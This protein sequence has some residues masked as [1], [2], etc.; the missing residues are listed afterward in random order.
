MGDAAKARPWHELS[1]LRPQASGRCNQLQIHK[2]QRKLI[3]S[4][5]G[6]A[7][8]AECDRLVC[9]PACL[10]STPVNWNSLSSCIRPRVQDQCLDII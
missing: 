10:V 2:V 1:D 5:V 8:V 6:L 9:M 3:L 7:R 4:L